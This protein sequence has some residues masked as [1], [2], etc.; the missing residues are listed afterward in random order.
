MRFQLKLDEANRVQARREGKSM[1]A[2]N[3]SAHGRLGQANML[4]G[5]DDGEKIKFVSMID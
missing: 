5:D 2:A 3:Q 1:S 4:R